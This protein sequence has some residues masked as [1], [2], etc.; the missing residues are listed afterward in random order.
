MNEVALARR[1]ALEEGNI[2]IREIGENFYETTIRPFCKLSENPNIRGVRLMIDSPG[3]ECNSGLQFCNLIRQSRVP[4]IA[5]I[6]SASSMGFLI[7]TQCHVR[8]AYPSSTFM[9]HKP[10]MA[11]IEGANIDDLDEHRKELSLYED[12]SKQMIFERTRIT[13]KDL[14]QQSTQWTMNAQEALKWGVVDNIMSNEYALPPEH[15]LGPVE[16]TEPKIKVPR[17]KK[18]K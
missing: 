8:I 6:V 3:G 18:Q 13:Q 14:D 1:E 7:A 5:E 10:W 9:W 11:Y 12:L 2:I 15:V 17:K 4:V 16:I